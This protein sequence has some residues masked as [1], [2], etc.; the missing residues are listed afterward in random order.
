MLTADVIFVNN[1]PF[2]ITCGVGIRLIMAEFMPAQMANQWVCSLKQIINL[3]SS[4]GF[5]IQTILM[6]IEFNKVIPKT[7]QVV[8]NTSAA[9][10]HD[11]EVERH[12]VVI[13]E[14]VLS[15]YGSHA[16]QKN[17]KYHDN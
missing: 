3:H 10:K 13:K 12:I 1:L 7:M 9:S 2:A 4:A 6:D 11:A 15:L 16:F 14:K 17:T 5:I 8:I